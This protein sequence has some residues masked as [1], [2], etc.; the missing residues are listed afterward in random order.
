[1][2]AV[3]RS[4]ARNGGDG[5]G[6]CRIAFSDCEDGRAYGLALDLHVAERLCLVVNAEQFDGRA[7]GEKR[8]ARLF[9]R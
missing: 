9:R 8:D 3:R 2:F 7:A 1:M 6:L 4:I 5:R